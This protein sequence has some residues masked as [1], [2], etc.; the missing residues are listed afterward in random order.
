MNADRLSNKV[1]SDLYRLYINS[2]NWTLNLMEMIPSL[3]LVIGPSEDAFFR[4]TR[5]FSEPSFKTICQLLVPMIFD[6]YIN[7]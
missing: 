4:A 5:I 6:F 3:D 7:K 2:V 1:Q